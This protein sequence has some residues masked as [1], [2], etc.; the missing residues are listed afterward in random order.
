[1]SRLGRSGGLTAPATGTIHFQIYFL[2][3]GAVR[4]V[5]DFGEGDLF[6]MLSKTNRLGTRKQQKHTHKGLTQ[7]G[8]RISRTAG[9]GR[10]GPLSRGLV[11]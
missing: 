9:S 4:P 2:L 6:R 8:E 11:R 10:V 7:C 3:L 1:M 5:H